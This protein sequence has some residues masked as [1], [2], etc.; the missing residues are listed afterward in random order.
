MLLAHDHPARANLATSIRLIA[1]SG[2]WFSGLAL[3]LLDINS[4]I[5][6]NATCM[7]FGTT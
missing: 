5:N 4:F 3:V 6:E 7:K 2:P 1:A